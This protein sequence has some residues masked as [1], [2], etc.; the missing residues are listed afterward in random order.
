MKI[1]IIILFL[2]F[3]KLSYSQVVSFD[4][5][6]N[7]ELY[8]ITFK[9]IEKNMILKKDLPKTFTVNGDMLSYISEF[10]G[11][12]ST[13]LSVKKYVTENGWGFIKD[14]DTLGL[15]R[16]F[17]KIHTRRLNLFIDNMTI[18]SNLNFSYSLSPII[19]SEDNKKA[20]LI[21]QKNSSIEVYEVKVYFFIK[22]SDKWVL[23]K[24]IAPYI[25]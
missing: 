18:K 14:V 22:Q 20:F 21:C 23:I 24:T 5:K 2:L 8:A 15:L 6:D 17:K 11:K 13:S 16:R 19:F 25:I 7:L 1:S 4:G 9:E 10:L 12:N 3:S